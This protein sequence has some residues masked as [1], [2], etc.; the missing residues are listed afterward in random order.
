MRKKITN[1]SNDRGKYNH[2]RGRYNL[3]DA[4]EM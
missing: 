3:L 2:T 4:L 1:T